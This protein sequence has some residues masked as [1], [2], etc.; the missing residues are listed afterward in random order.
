MFLKEESEA[1]VIPERNC[2]PVTEDVQEVVLAL[3]FLVA[4]SKAFYLA[5]KVIGGALL[6]DN[7]FVESVLGVFDFLRVDVAGNRNRSPILSQRRQ[8][9]FQSMD[10]Q[11]APP[12]VLQKDRAR[13]HILYKGAQGASARA[14]GSRQLLKPGKYGG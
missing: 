4:N 2:D 7:R 13:V 1:L 5:Q 3:A 6:V 8:L 14:T 9:G 10:L 12:R 11:V